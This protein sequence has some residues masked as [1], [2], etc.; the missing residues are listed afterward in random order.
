MG[1]FEAWGVSN[2]K[3]QGLWILPKTFDG[4]TENNED[5][6]ICFI[7]VEGFGS[8]NKVAEFD[9]KLYL[10]ALLISSLTLVNVVG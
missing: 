6:K 4:K 1:A 10:I 8:G 5:V 3:T 7:D 9:V 2:S